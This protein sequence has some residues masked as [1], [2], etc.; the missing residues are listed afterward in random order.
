VRIPDVA[1]PELSYQ[2]NPLESTMAILQLEDST[3]Y[4]NFREIVAE[5]APL[6]IQLK[7]LP[8]GEN[9]ALPGLIAQDVLSVENKQQVL[10]AVDN[11]F[12]EL[13]YTAGYQWRDL[14]VLHPGSPYL[15]ALISNFDR[16]HTHADDEALYIV[17]GECIFGF[18]RP[19]GSQV[20]LIVQAQEYINV[21]AGTEHWFCPTALLQLKAVRYFTTVG[22]WTPQYTNTEIYFRQPVARRSRLDRS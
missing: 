21:P 15:Y 14:T 18:V 8:V 6:N 13:K 7:R 4:T 20:E 11:Y 1:K 17:A 19:D 10:A 2:F 3:T 12:E 5:L 9:I 22:G 16:C